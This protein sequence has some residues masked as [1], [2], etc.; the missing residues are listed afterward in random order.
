M[1]KTPVFIFFVLLLASLS[2]CSKLVDVNNI[3]DEQYPYG[4]TK[5]EA[6]ESIFYAG[7]K[8]G[9][10]INPVTADAL[11]GTLYT[12]K[13][14]VKVLI[15]VTERSYSILYEDSVLMG[16]DNGKIHANY[17]KWVETL[18]RDINNAMSG[19][20]GVWVNSVNPSLAYEDLFNDQTACESLGKE[21]YQKSS[22]VQRGDAGIDDFVGEYVYDCL[23]KRGWNRTFQQESR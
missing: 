14:E 2:G 9:W 13:H 22:Q 1:Q 20:G 19:S 5:A 23:S 7:A 4:I 3:V 16:Y 18:R 21:K 6:V 15:P 8:R 12:R 11:E 10:Q 17:N